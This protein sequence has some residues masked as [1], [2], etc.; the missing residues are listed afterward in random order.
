MTTKDVQPPFDIEQL[1]NVKPTEFLTYAQKMAY[2]Q[3]Q[4]NPVY[5]QWIS[6]SNQSL[7][8]GDNVGAIPFLP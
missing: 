2:F 6:L 4:N 5:N 3:A 7:D 8:N 1:W